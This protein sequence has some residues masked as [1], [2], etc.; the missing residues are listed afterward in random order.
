MKTWKIVEIKL[1]EHAVVIEM[2]LSEFKKL[3]RKEDFTPVFENREAFLHVEGDP[4]TVF[5]ARKE[6]KK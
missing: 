6:D 1:P 3:A 4:L 5:Y 2:A